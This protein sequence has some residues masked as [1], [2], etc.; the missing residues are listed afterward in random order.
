MATLSSILPWRIPWTESLAG[1]SP[2]GRKELD[3]MSMHGLGGMENRNPNN[4]EV[5]FRVCFGLVLGKISN[6]VK[7]GPCNDIGCKA[8]T[9][10]SHTS[11][12]I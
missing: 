5:G 9:K 1:Y 2:W 8:K 7:L 10:N 11:I 4:L 6:R 12:S 3:M